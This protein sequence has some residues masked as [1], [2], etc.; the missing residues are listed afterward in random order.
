MRVEARRWFI[1]EKQQQQQK[2]KDDRR[3]F[4]MK[5]IAGC[6]ASCGRR[7]KKVEEEVEERDST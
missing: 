5:K 2:K 3:N 1:A 7:L 4:V 6:T